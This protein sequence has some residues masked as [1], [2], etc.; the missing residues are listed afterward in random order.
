MKAPQYYVARFLPPLLFD[1]NSDLLE[2]P[3]GVSLHTF[4]KPG[5]QISMPFCKENKLISYPQINKKK[6]E[7]ICYLSFLLEI[8]EKGSSMFLCVL[9]QTAA[10]CYM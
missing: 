3:V 8:A 7:R 4:T 10:I 2:R 9:N 6:I 1:G 5:L